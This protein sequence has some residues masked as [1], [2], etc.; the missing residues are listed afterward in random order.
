MKMKSENFGR[1]RRFGNPVLRFVFGR[2][3]ITVLLLLIQIFYLVA[4]FFWLGKYMNFVVE[5]L[6]LLGAVLVVYIINDDENPAYKIAWMLPV[7]VLPVLGTCLYLF[8]RLNFGHRWIHETMKKNITATSKWLPQNEKEAKALHDEDEYA[9]ALAG[10]LYNNGRYPVYSGCEAVYFPDG[11]AKIDELVRQLEQAET[12]IFM[13]YFIVDAGNVWDRILEVL[14]RKAAEGVE[15]RFM[16]DGMCS[17]ILLP[18]NYPKRLEKLGIKAKMYAPIRPMLSTHQNNRDHRKIVVIDGHMAFTGGINLADEYTNEKARFGCWKDCS[19]MVKG[20]CVR[21]FTALFLQMWNAQAKSEE[22][23]Y[24]HYLQ[25]T[26][27]KHEVRDGYMIPYGDGPYDKETLAENVYL[28]IINTA[29]RYVHIMT[30]YLILDHELVSA[31][32]YAVGRGVD[33]KLIIPHIPDK[34]IPFDIARTYYTELIPA[35]VKIYEFTPGF[36]HAKVFV[37]DD[38]C[39]VVGSINLDYRS[40]YL[41]FEDAVYLYRTPVI[42]DLERDFQETLEQSAEMSVEAYRKISLIKR[43]SGRIFRI[44]GPL[45]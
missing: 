43:M 31:L 39:G 40:L 44:F 38:I 10:Y 15:V 9:G 2:S 11:S 4:G 17:L 3:M 5:G 32:K 13:E 28:H 33:V 27:L 7:L 1:I 23:R 41:H 37:C 12:F 6:M 29:K 22:D 20:D 36:V 14:A 34:K 30:P 19:I 21:S 16:Y 26:K 42:A 8:V 24:G 25:Q 18:Y 35:G 45:M